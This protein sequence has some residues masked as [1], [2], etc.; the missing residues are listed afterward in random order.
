[1]SRIEDRSH[2]D[3]P[4][5]KVF[6]AIQGAGGVVPCES[7]DTLLVDAAVFTRGGERQVT[8]ANMTSRS[9]RARVSGRTVELGPHEVRIV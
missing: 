2:F 5:E 1:M 4:V 7:S 8:L 9:Q 3:L 6:A